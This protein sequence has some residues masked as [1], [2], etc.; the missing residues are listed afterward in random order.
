MKGLHHQFSKIQGK[1]L[2]FVQKTWFLFIKIL[3]KMYFQD[4]GSGDE[5]CPSLA[6]SSVVS[7]S[8]MAFL[9]MSVSIFRY[10]DFMK[11]V[12]LYK[13]VRTSV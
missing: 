5:S 8:Q 6:D 1:K 11:I 12:Q 4:G 7:L 13:L 2:G 10:I 9:S 3:T